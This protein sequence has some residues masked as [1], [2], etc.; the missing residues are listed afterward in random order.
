MQCL[1]ER[2]LKE[3][4]NGSLPAELIIPASE[5]VRTCDACRAR[6]AAAAEYQQAASVIG[7]MVTAS[8]ECPEYETLSAFVDEQLAGD[9]FAAVERH[10]LNCELC[11]HDLET[12]QE[13]RSKASL[14]PAVTVFPGTFS[15]KRTWTVFGWRSA[16]ATALGAAAVAVVLMMSNP[17]AVQ[18]PGNSQTIAKNT[19]PKVVATR[20]ADNTPKP[21]AVR[22]VE[23]TPGVSNKTATPTPPD[24]QPVTPKPN[25]PTNVEPERVAVLNDGS[26]TV[27]SS[28]GKIDVKSSGRNLESIVAASVKQKIRNGKL[29][30]DVRMAMS[31]TD[32]V[33]GVQGSITIKKLSPEPGGMAGSRPTFRWDEVSGAE[34]YR[35]EV[36]KLDGTTVLYQE[37]NTNEFRPGERLAPGYY[38]WT[39]WV[40]LGELAEWNASKVA[41]FRVLSKS[42]SDLLAAA[43]RNYSGSHLVMGTVYEKLGMT[44]E[45]AGEFRALVK[46]NP[47]SDLAAKMLAGTIRNR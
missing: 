17:V 29:P 19:A 16:A 6:L 23:P 15:R 28:G 44:S 9:A 5:H 14:A 27:Y 42:D 43:K 34:R 11:W 40:R 8:D 2:K 24:V 18:K 46:E 32:H 37:T 20:P 33:R 30:S 1:D 31:P 25:S 4:L 26:V 39:V 13:A 35:I 10:V 47:N 21:H 36:S 45:A 7:S 38:K 12:L 3:Y 22:P 41:A